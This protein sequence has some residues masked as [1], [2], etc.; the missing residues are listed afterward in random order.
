MRSKLWDSAHHIERDELP[1]TGEMVKVFTDSQGVQFDPD[2]Y[3][4]NYPEHMRKT[5]Y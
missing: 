4:K 3:D 5:I 1:S 2:E